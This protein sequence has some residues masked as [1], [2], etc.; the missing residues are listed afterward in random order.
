LIAAYIEDLGKLVSAPTVK[1]HLA[2]LRQLFDYLVVGQVMPTNPASAVRG[3]KHVVKRGLTPV[4]TPKEAR[5]LLRSID[6][7]TLA[8]LR[9]RALIATMIYSF[10]RVTATISMNT[11]DYF[12]QGPRRWFRLHEKGGKRHSVP[13]HHKAE[14]YM[15][16][17]LL[18]AGVATA[19]GTPLFRVID[20]KGQVTERRLTRQKALKMVKRRVRAAG[21]PSSICNHS[22]RAT[23]ITTY[24]LNGGTLEHAQQIACHESPRT[25]K[26][27]D[28][29]TDEVSLDEIERI[30]I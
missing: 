22:F 6:T 11:E 25:T 15:D 30:I 3:P 14:E 9:D 10:A 12:P 18:A 26:L 8:G 20:H 16:A 13:A 1:L 19:K 29:T 5:L 4:L 28:R 21:L 17:Y 2:A 27:Y 24:L 23:G 7:T